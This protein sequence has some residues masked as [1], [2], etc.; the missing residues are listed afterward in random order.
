MK[1]L[2]LLSSLL[3]AATVSLWGQKI[4]KI[5][6]I[7]GETYEGY[8]CE[9]VP[10]EYICVKTENTT[11]R[12]GWNTV[13]KTEKLDRD[14]DFSRGVLDVMILKTGRFYKGRI[15]ET[16]LGKSYRLELPDSSDVVVRYDNV[17]SISSEPADL[18]AGLWSQVDMLDRIDVRNGDIIEGFIVA[19][20]LGQSLTIRAKNSS[21][22][23]TI[24]TSE[25]IKYVK[26]PNPDYVVPAPPVKKEPKTVEPPTFA[27]KLEKVKID[28]IAFK[29]ATLVREADGKLV[30]K[31]RN[32]MK[33]KGR[34]IRLT[35]PVDSASTV[36]P[37]IIMLNVERIYHRDRS[38][39][40]YYKAGDTYLRSVY[41]SVAVGRNSAELL[42]KNLEL[43]YYLVL[44]YLEG[45]E[46]AIFE[47]VK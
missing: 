36:R 24:P 1:R 45:E 6:T 11:R 26:I 10:G 22:E 27:Q 42:V 34:S 15:V 38:R 30:L 44:P 43:G 47:V 9:Q 13:E 29:P 19:R 28:G 40:P 18:K 33:A 39:Y 31:N 35:I 7:G 20:L 5:Y 14:S 12:L 2:F 41:S 23:R 17:F 3:F 8:I 32:V 16:V 37:E 46:A 21:V 4:E 25:I